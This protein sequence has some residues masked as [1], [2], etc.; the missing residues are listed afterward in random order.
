V[1][2]P[3]ATQPNAMICLAYVGAVSLAAGLLVLGADL[4]RDERNGAILARG[5]SK[6]FP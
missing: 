4:I 5:R 3:E 6:L 1:L 2:S